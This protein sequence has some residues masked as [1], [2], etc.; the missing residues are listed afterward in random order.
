MKR[1]GAD[2][3]IISRVIVFCA[4]YTIAEVMQIHLLRT[5]GRSLPTG[6]GSHGFREVVDLR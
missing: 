3:E 6:G 2:F 4:V 5:P 1:G